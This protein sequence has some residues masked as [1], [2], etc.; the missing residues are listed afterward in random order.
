MELQNLKQLENTSH[1]DETLILPLLISKKCMGKT[2]VTSPFL[3]KTPFGLGRKDVQNLVTEL[4]IMEHIETLVKLTRLNL[5]SLD[6][7]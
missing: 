3:Q 5:S 4:R 7:K 6:T 1:V 2:L